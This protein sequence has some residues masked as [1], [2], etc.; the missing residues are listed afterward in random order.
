MLKHELTI[1]NKEIQFFTSYITGYTT[2]FI[3]FIIT[4][5]SSV[6]IFYHNKGLEFGNVENDINSLS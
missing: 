4:K 6:I 2:V 3:N 1:R 5:K